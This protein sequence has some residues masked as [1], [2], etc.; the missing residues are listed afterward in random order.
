MNKRKKKEELEKA[1]MLDPEGVKAKKK[2]RRKRIVIG[3]LSAFGVIILSLVVAVVIIRKMGENS[4]RNSVE[5]SHPIIETP[6]TAAAR[7]EQPEEWKEGWIKYGD[8]VYEYNEDLL[9]FLIM[10]IDKN[11]EV[12]EVAEGT[13]GGQAD[14]LFLL[15]LNPRDDSIKIVAINR[16]T[17]T[18]I[19]I[20]NE[21]GDYVT[22]TKAQI[23]V[24]HGFGNGLEESCEYQVEA[25]RKLLY[26]MPIHGYAAINMA[27]I[28]IINDS[29]GGVNVEVLSDVKTF[30]GKLVFKQGEAKHL[31]GEDAYHY[32]HDRDGNEFGSADMR[33]ARQKQYLTNFVSQAKMAAKE[34]MGV[35][36]TL[37][38]DI[39]PYMTTDISFD[40]VAYLAPEVIGYT[41]DS[42]NIKSPAG[43]TVAGEEF[44]E[45]YV[46]EDSLFETVLDVFYDEVE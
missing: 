17:M 6:E 38:N 9:N 32:I 36:T 42:Y 2:M 12:K 31:M 20:Y 41:F 5:I 11:G 24:Q 26:N 37:Y 27:A 33:L 7:V 14:A 35:V 15:V 13:N 23:A 3:I 34:D 4:L 16:N 19:D 28:P 21:Q 22:T 46:D 40:E 44:E 10:G 39:K 43:E 25:V 29:V 1:V 8:K 18:D 45:F 30:S